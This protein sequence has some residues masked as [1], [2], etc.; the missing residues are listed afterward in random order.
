[1]FK[2]L[3][4]FLDINQKEV[5]RLQVLVEKVN[6]L[7]P[8]MAKLKKDEDFTATTAEFKHRLSEGE[9]LNDLLPEAFALV[10]E[11]SR[12]TLGLRPF[13]VQLMAALAFHEGKV[14]E[15]KTGEGKTLSAIPALYLNSLS[16]QGVHLV[17]V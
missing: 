2:F 7:E 8:Q 6:A 9:T 11:A 15:Q 3:S 13:D 14:A 17:T 4:K 16:G 5:N 10:R 1:M 12:R